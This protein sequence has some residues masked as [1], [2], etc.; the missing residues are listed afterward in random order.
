MIVCSTLRRRSG[1]TTLPVAAVLIVNQCAF[2]DFIN[3]EAPVHEILKLRDLKNSQ[4]SRNL[5]QKTKY[6]LKTIAYRDHR[7]KIIALKHFSIS[8]I[9][10]AIPLT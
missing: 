3:F 8:A 2:V 7:R 5:F 1:Y 6:P 9:R 4:E 10:L